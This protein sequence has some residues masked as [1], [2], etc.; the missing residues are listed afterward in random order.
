MIRERKC[1]Q[2]ALQRAWYTVSLPNA[3][4]TTS[5]GSSSNSPIVTV[6]GILNS[7]KDDDGVT[8]QREKGFSESKHRQGWGRGWRKSGPGSPKAF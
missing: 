8:Q 6:T 7:S 4:A 2:T 3:A 1:T 5:R